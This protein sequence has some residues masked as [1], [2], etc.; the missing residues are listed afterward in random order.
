MEGRWG[1]RGGEEEEGSW[2]AGAGGEVG[3]VGRVEN[4]ATEFPAHG[5][6]CPALIQHNVEAGVA[7]DGGA[8]V[9]MAAAAPMGGM[10]GG[11]A[12]PPMADMARSAPSSNSMQ[13]SG[14][15]TPSS[16]TASEAP[17]ARAFYGLRISMSS[18]APDG[19]GV[20]GR[21]RREGRGE[22]HE[23]CNELGDDGCTEQMRQTHIASLREGCADGRLERGAT[24]SSATA[25]VPTEKN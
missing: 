13:K 24:P 23:T 12:A 22:D 2:G 16:A 6:T 9:M 11:G 25:A 5:A 8:P 15:A 3:E 20:R 1:R 7:M 10:G 21:G 14:G 18:R 17:R 19:D 4:H